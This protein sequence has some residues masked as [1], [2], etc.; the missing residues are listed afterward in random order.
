MSFSDE[1]RINRNFESSVN[2]AFDYGNDSKIDSFI[3]TASTCDLI[4]RLTTPAG[5]SSSQ[6]AK[7]LI[8]PYGRG[9][10]HVVLVALSLLTGA[11]RDAF[12]PLIKKIAA[13][14]PKLAGYLNAYN[15]SGNRLLPVIIT[16]NTSNLAQSFLLALDQAL[17]NVGAKELM[18]RTN[19]KLA[20][21]S[22]RTWETSYP[23]TYERFSKL[24]GI[25]TR[26]FLAR[27]EKFDR[28][29]YEE[30]LQ[31]YPT[32]TSGS[33]FN[34]FS[35]V[36]PVDAYRQVAQAVGTIGFSGLYIVYDEFGKYLEANIAT[37][38]DSDTRLLQ[39]LA[40][41]CT[42]SSNTAQMHL[43]LICHKDISNYIDSKLQQTR[44]DGWRGVSGR[45]EHL[46][47]SSDYSESYELID[48]V[49]DVTN[50]LH[51]KLE[52]KYGDLFH[53]LS[54]RYVNIGLFDRQ[55]INRV[56]RG[57]F[58][59]HPVTT[60][61]LPR[62]SEKVAQNE[63]TLFTYLAARERDGFEDAL[64]TLELGEMPP[65]VAPYA[66]YDYF[67]PLFNREPPN[68][69]IRSINE[70]IERALAG[71]PEDEVDARNLV[72]LVGLL[73]MAECFNVLPPTEITVTAILSE[74][75][76]SARV[77][78]CLRLATKDFSVLRVRQ[79]DGYLQVKNNPGVD[80]ES[81]L[82][83][84]AAKIATKKSPVDL[85]QEAIS[86][87]A[88]Y[89]SRHNNTYEIVRYFECHFI[90]ADD[91][92]DILLN[93][94]PSQSHAAGWIVG[95]VP[96]VGKDNDWAAETLTN[97]EGDSWKNGN[98]RIIASISNIGQ[99][100]WSSLYRFFAIGN[101][102]QEGDFDE[103]ALEEL[104]ALQEDYGKV[105]RTYTES[106]F[107]PEKRLATYFNAGRKI[108]V[109]RRSMLSD[110]LSKICDRTF[111]YTPKINNE[112]INKDEP[113]GTAIS[114]RNKI[115]AG[116]CAP[117]IQ[118]NFGLQ[119]SAQETSIMRSVF[120]VTGVYR[121]IDTTPALTL[122]PDTHGAKGS[123]EPILSAINDFIKTNQNPMTLN[124]LYER[125]CGDTLGI[126]MKRGP[127]I[128]YLAAYLR[129]MKKDITILRDSNETDLDVDTLI[130]MDEHP[131]RY[132][133]ENTPW[134]ESS[135]VYI[136]KL[137]RL[138]DGYYQASE[139]DSE[140]FEHVAEGMGRWYLRLPKFAKVART[141][142][143]GDGRRTHLSNKLIEFRKTMSDGSLGRR[144]RL[145][146]EIPM[147][148]GADGPDE[149][150]AM[151]IAKIKEQLDGFVD[152]TL[153]SI[154]R[155][156]LGLFDVDG[157]FG[158]NLD[159][160]MSNWLG[161][162][163]KRLGGRALDDDS[164]IVIGAIRTTCSSRRFSLKTLCKSVMTLKIE[165][166][167][168]GTIDAFIAS[169]SHAVETVNGVS[170][171]ES[172][173]PQYT[174]S[175]LTPDGESK[176]SFEKMELSPRAVLLKNTLASAVEE[177]GQS[178]TLSEKRQA[179]IEVLEEML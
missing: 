142:Y 46:E 47:I 65:F 8:G 9:K 107:S 110:Y 90:S 75:M 18:P 86:G 66:L 81:T 7:I 92:Q 89:P 123:I 72:K 26:E 120:M 177:M 148:L 49:V 33:E 112:A 59:L 15:E 103:V 161:D 34:T 14:H 139:L 172:H 40:E 87:K 163:E 167:D 174:F 79:S 36:D 151:S 131:E 44:V 35:G 60:Y 143:L 20:I 58:P 138:F 39:D 130:D 48:S 5:E 97:F 117:I 169:I 135:Q 50:G 17:E 99:Q 126:G 157:S 51:K 179:L 115:L 28:S 68:S 170:G 118:P 96:A 78:D 134:N 54:D 122:H 62:I 173:E 147:V 27:L 175:L 43:L 178:I 129:S 19:F 113:T 111:P 45:Y 64:A 176:R 121:D 29:A 101:L 12:K 84:E 85:L 171:L 10:S 73:Y 160:A 71:L 41:A 2:I 42:R 159:E 4:E 91:L 140:G 136:E 125:L 164:E 93:G 158:N 95:V 133:I 145:L 144:E 98:S 105:L 165:D 30:F 74:L 116:I 127:V 132:T 25:P 52:S 63:R 1:V 67:E 166:W 152:S 119:G 137:S 114:S 38:K 70:S 80:I 55:D 32:L 155:D 83:R 37:A 11:S 104:S 141:K 109:T 149:Q 16:G 21:E 13:I 53:R 146:T 69:P 162:T 100:D 61:L 153:L 150:A 23:E 24:T 128:L 106:F 3:P 6:R 22:I 168:D 108:I 77:S 76:S 56:C 102:M 88:L 82:E 156:L 154:E 57:C 124:V 31:V 94:I